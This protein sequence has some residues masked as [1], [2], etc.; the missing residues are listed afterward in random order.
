MHMLR[1]SHFGKCAC[2]K[3]ASLPAQGHALSTSE[4]VA[5]GNSLVQS[6]D[7]RTEFFDLISLEARRSPDTTKH[8]LK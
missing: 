7:A 2:K 1:R 8:V 3:D 6:L 4:G 5:F